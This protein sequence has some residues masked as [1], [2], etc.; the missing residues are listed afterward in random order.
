MEY[1][2]WEQDSFEETET[3]VVLSVRK[4]LNFDMKIQQRLEPDAH[5]IKISILHMAFRE[6]V[7]NINKK[8]E[9]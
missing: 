1:K 7:S 4:A 9:N 8:T 2:P 3:G 5:W 6:V